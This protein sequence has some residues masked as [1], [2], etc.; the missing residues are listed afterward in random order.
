[1][2]VEICLAGKV[3]VVTGAHGGVGASVADVLARAGASLM[4]SDQD[5]ARLERVGSQLS[6]PERHATFG[7]DIGT[8]SGCRALI[9]EAINRFGRVDILVNAAAVL[10]RL[11]LAA[12]TPEV[13]QQT[14]DVNLRS[15][16][17]LC[18]EVLPA[19]ERQGQGVIVNFISPS[20]FTGGQVNATH[21]AAS[22][23]GVVAL[24]RG[25]ARQYGPKGIRTNILCPGTTDTPMIRD[26]LSPEEI[27]AVVAGIPMNRL[28]APREIANGVLMLSSDLASF[29]NGAVLTIDGGASLRP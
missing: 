3:A 26:T 24:S 2:A 1:M 29:V 10:R 16:L 15:I 21:Y 7:A 5:P 18:Q 23:A 12:V 11:P 14:I 17:I 19:M 4:I 9:A 25:L 28:A 13:F 6:N 20:A 22:K 27:E 8:V